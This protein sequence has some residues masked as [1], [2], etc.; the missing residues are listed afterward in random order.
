LAVGLSNPND[1]DEL[2][3]RHAARKPVVLIA[4][5][6]TELPATAG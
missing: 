4:E 1:M 5:V 6:G 2:A 3:A